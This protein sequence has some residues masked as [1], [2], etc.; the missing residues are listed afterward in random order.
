MESR[1]VAAPIGIFDSGIGG[2][3]VAHQVQRALP[4]ESLLYFGDTAHM[5]YGDKSQVT[6]QSYSIKIAHALLEKGCKAILIACNSASA[7]AYELVR[8]YV[9]SRARVYNVIDPVVQYTAQH[10]AGQQVGLIGTKQT[11]SSGLFSAKFA[12]TAPSVN[13]KPLATPLLAHMIEQGF[14]N[15]SVSQH[16]IHSYLQDETLRGIDSLILGCTHY[17][18]IKEEVST[19][20]EEK[21]TMLDTSKIVAEFLRKE[22][23]KE[24]LLNDGVP[25]P[26][27]FLVSD[28]TASFEASA[29]HFFGEPV[30]LEKYP[31]WD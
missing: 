28:F 15:N 31:L 23:E 26:P 5:P 17:P 24:G 27:Q 4:Q 9:G 25:E 18:L 8:E 12:A 21:V 6:I 14:Y 1:P 22:L 3:T 19:F 29:R 2:L 10:H 16:I 11:I 20:F 13:L 7:A 30:H